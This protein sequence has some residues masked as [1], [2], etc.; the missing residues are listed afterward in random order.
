MRIRDVLMVAGLGGYYFDDFQAIKRGAKQDGFFYIGDPITPGHSR[1]RQ[2]GE[3]ISVML[4]LEDGQVGIGDCVGIQY[5]GVVGRDPV[6]IA[7]KHIPPLEKLVSTSLIG[8]DIKNFKE[9]SQFIDSLKINGQKLYSWI[10]YGFSQAALD[11]VAK[12]RGITM[13]EVIADEYGLTISDRIIPI[14]P[15]SGDDRYIGADKMILKKAPVLPQ[16]L[17]NN[18][19]KIG[20]KGEKLIAYVE[21]LSE[22]IRKFGGSDYTPEIHLDV[23]GMIGDIFDDDIGKV[24]QYLARLGEAAKPFRLSVES[25]ILM[26]SKEKLIPAFSRLKE[27]LSGNKVD[28]EIV[29]DDYCNTLEDIKE[30]VDAD[31]VHMVQVKPP[32]LGAL[33]N[34]VEAVLYCRRHGVKAFLGGTCNSTDVVARVSAHVALATQADQMYGKPGMGVDVAMQIP[35]NEMQRTLSLIK[36]KRRSQN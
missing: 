9:F 16:G 8:E 35:Y 20:Q 25:P 28:V 3:C 1:I 12:V 36:S 31:A 34:S 29:A 10:R 26:E 33:H 4:I 22:R 17:F 11:A 6:L 5:S 15:Q 18:I 21:W 13:A 32:D 24:T 7:E 19:E 27:S 30:F 23:Y 2:P 14:L